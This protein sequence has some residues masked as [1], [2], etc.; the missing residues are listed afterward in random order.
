MKENVTSERKL[1]HI[2]IVSEE[3]VEAR[4]TPTGLEDVTLVHCALPDL[5]ITQVNLET[6]FLNHAFKAPI[7]VTGMTGG[8]EVAAKINGQIAEVVEELGL[9]MGVGSQRAAIE[10]PELANTF[11][12]VRESAPTA[13]VVA[14]IGIPQLRSDPVV[15][16]QKA[17]DMID[18]DALAIHLNPIQETVQPGGEP[19]FKKGLDKIEKIVDKLSVPVIVKETGGGISQGVAL[20]LRDAGVAA[21]DVSGVGGTS[22]A[23][24]EYYRAKDA[25]NPLKERLGELLWDWG[26][27]TAISVAEVRSAVNLPIISSGGIRNGVEIAKSIALGAQ[28]GGMASPVLKRA[29]SGGVPSV[30]DLLQQTI[31]EIRAVM[32][33]TDSKN[34]ESLGR[35]DLVLKGRTR[36]WLDQRGISTGARSKNR[37]RFSRG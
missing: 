18:A 28:L 31:E 30:R 19:Q 2:K 27:P 8:H 36:E 1:S 32:F 9:G 24:V 11:G 29:I 22:W 5:D 20:H 23:A 17:V 25:S 37:R 12:I 15:M 26:L 6:R 34:V 14:N 3:A 10:N 4:E 13:F 35:V 21:I 33:L 7:Y 16:G